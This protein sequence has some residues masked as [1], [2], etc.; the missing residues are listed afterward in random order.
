MEIVGYHN[1]SALVEVNN[2]FIFSLKGDIIAGSI[3]FAIIPFILLRQPNSNGSQK[4]CILPKA[5]R[6]G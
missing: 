6:K 5:C 2:Q 4:H 3:F 1:D